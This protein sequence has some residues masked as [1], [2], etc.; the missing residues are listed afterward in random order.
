MVS[1]FATRLLD[2]A[3]EWKTQLD[4]FNSAADMSAVG[5]QLPRLLGLA[6]ASTLYRRNEVLGPISSQFSRGGNEV[7]FGTVGNGGVAEGLFWETLNAAG[8]IQVPLVLSVWDDGYGISVPNDLQVT[9]GSVSRAATG[10]EFEDG[11][12]GVMSAR[13]QVGTSR[14]SSGPIAR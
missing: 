3:G 6:W 12:G 8:V 2:D 4:T 7:A 9:K 11:V 14:H 13:W 10:F 5:A 1:H